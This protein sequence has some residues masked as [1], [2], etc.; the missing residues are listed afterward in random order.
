MTSDQPSRTQGFESGRMNR[1]RVFHPDGHAA[2][3]EGASSTHGPEERTTQ[4]S[5]VHPVALLLN[6]LLEKASRQ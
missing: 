1:F 4:T 6:T 3:A 5:A 2:I